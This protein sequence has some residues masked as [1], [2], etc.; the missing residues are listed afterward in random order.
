[1][2]A[3]SVPEP[4]ARLAVQGQATQ[5]QL[6]DSVS[7]QEKLR[8]EL[9]EM[10]IENERVKAEQAEMK[11][12]H[13][14]EIQQ[15]AAKG[16]SLLTKANSRA[17]EFERVAVH[18]R[19]ELDQSTRA[20]QTQRDDMASFMWQREGLV[21][22]QQTAANIRHHNQVRNLEEEVVVQR[23]LEQQMQQLALFEQE[24]VQFQA[25]QNIARNDQI[26]LQLRSEALT[27]YDHLRVEHEWETERIM[28]EEHRAH[29][30]QEQ[31]GLARAA[32]AN[33]EYHGPRLHRPLT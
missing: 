1:M 12:Q 21:A 11:L 29:L 25:E 26:V 10:K 7:E 4:P 27:L 14:A 23:Q 15:V 5:L 31:R 9:E 3:A 32:Q 8:A 13:K 22:F 30:E 17:D 2:A 19:E 18:T 20:N 6:Q 28:Q 24:Q 33:E 16:L